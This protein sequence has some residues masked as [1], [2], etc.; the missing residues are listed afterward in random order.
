MVQVSSITHRFGQRVALNEVSF[1]VERGKL[2]GLLGPNGSGKSTLF[3]ILTTLIAP[4]S[5][6]A[7]IAGADVVRNPS[8]VRRR[9][10]VVFQKP[11]LDGKLS[12]F[13][14]LK[15]QG[16]LYG[17]AGSKLKLRC[18]AMMERFD[19]ADRRN[20]R[21][22]TLSGGLQRRVE[23]AKSLLHGPEV[24]I[25]DEPSTGL[26]PGARVGLMDQLR[27]LC[28]DGVTCLMTTHL[29]VDA[30]RCDRIGVLDQGRLVALDT[31]QSLKKSVGGD[32]LTIQSSDAA[33]LARR[34]NERFSIGSDVVDGVVR[35]ERENGHMFLTD[36]IEAFPGEVDSVTV[37]KPT[38]EDVFVHLTG[39]RWE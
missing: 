35:I 34:V 2:F 22:E 33:T 27:A 15:H 14:N 11:S 7:S 5:G 24:L 9:I 29:M 21:A 10:G 19:V 4:A 8:A 26:D 18:E 6:T 23:L 13:E 1:E 17:L 38:L 39:H 28:S 12:V 31:P 25:L 36:L 37:G 20:D 32:V 16:H 30:D 3:R